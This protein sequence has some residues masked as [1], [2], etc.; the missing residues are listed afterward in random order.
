MRWEYAELL[1]YFAGL[2]L[3]LHELGHIFQGHLRLIAEASIAGY[4]LEAIEKRALEQAAD[5]F[6]AAHLSAIAVRR[7]AAGTYTTLPDVASAIGAAIRGLMLPPL[8]FSGAYDEIDFSTSEHPDL[9]T[10]DVTRIQICAMRYAQARGCTDTE[11]EVAVER[12]AVSLIPAIRAI[13]GSAC[14]FHGDQ[15]PRRFEEH[16][17]AVLGEVYQTRLRHRLVGH[18]YTELHTTGPTKGDVYL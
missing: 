2:G 10:R 7:S 11:A 9:P 15:L 18:A 17:A 6:A 1:C 4:P 16:E 12:M 14:V 13:T 8:L 5:V 3:L